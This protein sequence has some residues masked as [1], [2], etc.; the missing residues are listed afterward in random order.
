MTLYKP[1]L[2]INRLIVFQSGHKAFDCEFHAGVNVIRGRNSSGKTTIM[3]M[4][5]FSL[6]AENIRWKQEALMC[7]DTLVEVEL[8][9]K[10]ATLRREISESL[11]R[12]MAI[13]WGTLESALKAG[14]QDWELY[15]F[16]R[17]AHRI[18]FSQ[19]LIE[20]LEMPQ[21]Q[22]DGA[23]N[24]TLHQLLRV[25]YADQPSV[26]SPIFRLDSFDTPLT[27]DMV[28]GYLCGVY[29]DELYS[30]QLRLRE[31]DSLLGK[32]E[33]ELRSI[34]NVLGRSGQSESLDFLNIKITE[35]EEARTQQ[36]ANLIELKQKRTIT[37][38]ERKAAQAF[39]DNL[40]Q[41]LNDMRRKE[42]EAKDQLH[43]LE[44]DQTDS[45][46]F[47]AELRARLQ[48]LDESKETR[49]YFGNLRFDFCPSC[50]SPLLSEK[51]HDH[52]HL[53]TQELGDGR[54][55]MQLLRMRNEINVQLKE[56]ESLLEG[57][58]K[59][60]EELRTNI[61]LIT[62]QLRALE[63]KYRDLESSWSSEV[64]LAIEE[65]A[66]K[67]GNLDE[68]IRQAYERQ[69]LAAVIAEL[70][71]K[72]D[73]LHNEKI[74]LEDRVRQLA[75]RQDSRKAEVA[76]TVSSAMQRLLK[77]DLPLQEEFKNPREVI[78][79][80]VENAVY[81]NGAKNFSESS[82]VVLRHIF[83][84]ALLTASIK[85][86]YMRVP[87]FMMLDGIDDGGMEKERSHRLQEIIVNECEGF[88]VDFQLIFA[89]S[90]I[91]PLLER[92]D[93][94]AGRSFSPN[95]RSLDVRN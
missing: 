62:D 73:L 31:I 43:S 37:N 22:G 68:E 36:S 47:V 39:P 51:D 66:R 67:I 92:E 28:G 19:A 81:V 80:F 30:A 72:R 42:F 82:A 23:S 10:V 56:S 65:A 77:L 71:A 5:A 38:K 78:F 41:Q 49:S 32:Q 8:N 60:I 52:C 94:V 33:S 70:Q 85:H 7:T 84:L 89:T 69:K 46:M 40:R 64:E 83:H 48:N 90:E 57:R 87:R 21:A 27:R 93:L 86:P 26:H 61:P 34:Y 15:P 24:L 91:N 88:D 53:C 75:V 74:K 35:L 18:S 4:L 76:A 11:K 13:Y 17:S 9:G 44:L 2:K 16:L 45:T 29:D 54:G 50:L 14:S 1:T 58:A 95:A 79:D 3:D 12:P 55:E 25:L 63:Q 59:N 6:G 20:A